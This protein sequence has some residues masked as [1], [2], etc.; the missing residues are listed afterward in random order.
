[1]G[2]WRVIAL[3]IVGSLALAAPA[4][5][6][7]GPPPPKAV[8]G[9]AVKVVATGV[10]TPTAIAFVGSNM[11]AGSG[12]SENGASG[13]LFA[14]ANGTATK[15]PGTPS[16]VFGLTQRTGT[17]YVSSGL[18]VIAYRGF[19][20]TRFT[21]SKTI[22]TVK[23]GEP[24]LV[25]LAS[26]PDGRIYAGVSFD[27]QHEFGGD[28]SGLAQSVI[29][30]RPDGTHR[31]V[32]ARGMRQ[33]FQMTFP[34]GSPNPYVSVLGQ[35]QGRI[36]LD[37]IVVARPGADF[38][39][40]TCT[41][42]PGQGCGGFAWPLVFL[43]KH[44]SPMGIGAIGRTLYVALFGGRGHGP[45]VVTVSTSGGTVKPFLFGFAAPVVALRV[46]DKA[47]YVGDLTGTIYQVAA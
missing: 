29:S 30:M 43:P 35:D 12:P 36:P 37:Q 46:H 47:I 40:P 1:M 16:M 20:G 13:G 38:G 34:V 10:G 45:E 28:P 42:L 7:D 23:R 2:S 21:S 14:V 24:F 25:G 22:Y 41:R 39:F 32:V 18:K 17:L 6:A 9:H 11:F 19:D 27:D 8:N 44:A 26:G 4:V 33:P 31:R 3:S 5:A 15:I